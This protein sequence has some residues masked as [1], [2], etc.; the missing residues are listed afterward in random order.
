[1]LIVAAL[2]TVSP[3][4]IDCGL[5]AAPVELIVMF[6]EYVPAVS[7]TGLTEMLRFAGVVPPFGVTSSQLPPEVVVADVLKVMA[8]PLLATDT[9]CP[10]GRELPGW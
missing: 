9:F 8:V 1:M 5:L 4:K 7:P 6:P 10:P 2:V 3:T